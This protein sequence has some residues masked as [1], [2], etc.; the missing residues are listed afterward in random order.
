[1]TTAALAQDVP[2]PDPV[3][4]DE[5]LQPEAFLYLAV[6][7]NG[8]ESGLIAEVKEDAD[9]TLSIASDQLR[10][11]GIIPVP[12]A[13]RP[14]GRVQLD[15]LPAVSF[16]YDAALQ[17]LDFTATDAGR[18]ARKVDV[19]GKTPDAEKAPSVTPSGYG[20]LMNYSLSSS[21][22]NAAKRRPY[23]F[24]GVSG[25][26]EARTYGP[27]GVFSQGFIAST[28]D[29]AYY[30]STR[31]Q[32]TWSYSDPGSLVTYRGGDLI[33]GGL[34]WTR[35]SRLGGAQIQ[36]SFSLRSD[37]VTIPVPEL[38]GSAAVPSTVDVYL[39]NARRYSGAVPAGPFEIV[40]LPISTGN[41]R[42]RIVVRDAQGQEVETESAFY[43]SSKM[44]AP[45]LLDFSAEAGFARNDFGRDSN[46][47]DGRP[48]GSASVRYGIAD[49]LTVEAHAEGGEDLI[50]AGAG[51]VFSLGALGVGSLAGAASRSE[52]GTG[53]LADA[54]VEMD[55]VGVRMQ[56]RVQRTFGDYDDI[57]SVTAEPVSRRDNEV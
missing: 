5:A 37:L 11:V 6:S 30:D 3:A 14:D 16:V 31:L 33:A 1:M 36:R 53:Y 40:N 7:I 19:R 29:D 22:D 13:L 56:G 48:M 15:Q 54:G 25:A 27:Y 46:N 21:V 41:G 12:S 35:P 32:S 55:L 24:Q 4:V 50:N 38:S 20:A 23:A 10:N 34:G 9:G 2:V 47:Y 42:A 44:L 28:S 26:F 18:A 17:S 8:V 43:A 49:R 57:A 39:N 52:A 45:G 51:A